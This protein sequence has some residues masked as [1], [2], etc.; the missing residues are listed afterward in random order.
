MQLSSNSCITTKR[1][2][3]SSKPSSS[4]SSRRRQTHFPRQS[5]CP[6][7]S[8]PHVPVFDSLPWVS[9]LDVPPERLSPWDIADLSLLPVSDDEPTLGGPRLGPDYARMHTHD[10]SGSDEERLVPGVGPIRR[11]KTSLRSNPLTGVT[12]DVPAMVRRTP[13]PVSQGVRFG[14]GT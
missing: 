1:R 10:D 9:N 11:R 6:F 5:T 12:S 14:C 4:R 3:A 7:F 13:S 2:K 8:T